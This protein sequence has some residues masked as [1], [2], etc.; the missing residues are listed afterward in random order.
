MRITDMY[1]EIEDDF[2]LNKI[3]LS[4]QC[5]RAKL[6]DDGRVR[7]ITKNHVIYLHNIEK[8]KYFASCSEW[9]WDTIW[10]NYFDMERNYREIRKEAQGKH[11][12]IQKAIEAGE[13]LR[14]LK[15]DPWETLITFILSQR[16][17]IPAI[18]KSVELLA[19][20][21]GNQI[22]TDC[23]TIHTFP[24]VKEMESA[25][26]EE[27]KE[28]GLGY[29]VPYVLDAI[30]KVASGTLDLDA[31]RTYKSEDLFNTLLTING[32]GKKV[33][34]CV[35]LFA[36]GRM[37]CV[38]IDVWISKAICEECGGESPFPLFEKYAGIIQQ[39]VFYYQRSRRN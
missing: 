36:Y 19:N 34:D 20:K 14:I 25:I 28:C 35:R 5:F 4:G 8:Q 18:A 23:E 37:E 31:M 9:E 27:L 33:A 6:F 22:K 29:R 13:G 15:Q 24:L 12:F 16:K 39:Y 10:R 7:F 21:Y 2:D 26:A 11:E 1:I 3:A 38:P 32:V 30:H 17:S